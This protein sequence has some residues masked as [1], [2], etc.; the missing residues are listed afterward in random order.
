VHGAAQKPPSKIYPVSI[1]LEFLEA[2]VKIL[3]I[4]SI[5]G[6]KV[7]ILVKETDSAN[8]CWA[9][10]DSDDRLLCDHFFNES[11]I[12]KIF[13][14]SDTVE[15]TWE[16]SDTDIPNKTTECFEADLSE[17]FKYKDS[18]ELL[19]SI[20]DLP[21]LRK[22]WN[23]SKKS[24]VGIW[25]SESSKF[26]LKEDGAFILYSA[27][28]NSQLK[29]ASNATEWDTQPWVLLLRDYSGSGN[30]IGVRSSDEY[31]LHLSCLDHGFFSEIFRRGKV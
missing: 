24:L 16:E 6:Y 11:P 30:S 28:K 25:E 17:P 27:G 4:P 22:S 26:E 15:I 29:L 2:F 7:E 8:E 31:S 5:N 23:A 9:V 3:K 14:Y 21:V 1:A 20:S 13:K 19:S 10:C 18:Q 12:T